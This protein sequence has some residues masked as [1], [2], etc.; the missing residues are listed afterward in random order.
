MTAPSAHENHGK[1]YLAHVPPDDLIA[2]MHA[3]IDQFHYPVSLTLDDNT[4]A[5]DVY[6]YTTRR[7]RL[8]LHME[9]PYGETR[10]RELLEF[11]EQHGVT[12]S[13]G[14]P[15]QMGFPAAVYEELPRD[16]V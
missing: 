8:K 6:R 3:A 9:G 13:I 14:D 11:A 16:R 7:Y 10:V 2:I 1:H 5:H 4:P 12:V 15:V